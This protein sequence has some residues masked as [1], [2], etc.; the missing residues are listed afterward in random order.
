MPY[1]RV[2]LR[3]YLAMSTPRWADY[4]W[5]AADEFSDFRTG[6]CMSIVARATVSELLD[7]FPSVHSTEKVSYGTLID[8]ANDISQ[9]RH[10]SGHQIGFLQCGNAVLVLEPSSYLALLQRLASKMSLRRELV[11]INMPENG[12]KLF[13]WYVDGR[14]KT[15][16]EIP[17]SYYREGYEPDALLEVMEVIGGLWLFDGD[18]EM[19][20]PEWPDDIHVTEATFALCEAVTGVRL[21]E[22]LL[23]E[24]MY[25]VPV[26]G[27]IGSTATSR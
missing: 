11:N 12:E 20:D 7:V 1:T 27:D 2:E 24:S 26:L 14:E 17:Q 6:L 25:V 4:A 13:A 3:Y 22:Q 8:R 19:E 21:T 10:Q 9:T 15:N 16:F 18:L 5:L 23:T